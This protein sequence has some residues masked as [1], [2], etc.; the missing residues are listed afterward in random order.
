[1][2]SLAQEADVCEDGF[3]RT[4]SVAEVDRLLV[5]ADS[6]FVQPDEQLEHVLTARDAQVAGFGIVAIEGGRGNAKK[7]EV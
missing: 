2:P 6:V 7:R 4:L 3:G 5:V 1:M